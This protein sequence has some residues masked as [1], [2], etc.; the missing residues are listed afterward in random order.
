MKREK[1]T[2]TPIKD[3]I[4]AIMT[5]PNLPFDPEDA[6]IWEIWDEIVGT[7]I[8]LNAR[9]LWIKKGR[10]RVKVTDPIW[11]QELGFMQESIREK[12]NRRLGRQAVLKLEFRL[13]KD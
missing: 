2:L 5:D 12:L 11:L 3:I 10:L 4:S 6:F 7:E 9:P 1:D 13:Q 8:G